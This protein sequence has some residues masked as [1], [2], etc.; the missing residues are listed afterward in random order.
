METASVEIKEKSKTELDRLMDFIESVRISVNQFEQQINVR[1]GY[2]N[3]QLHN[4]ANINSKVLLRI[5]LKYPQLNIL[6]LITGKHKMIIKAN[7]NLLS[8]AS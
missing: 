1:Q 2:L 3:Q 5:S 6:W 8:L 7:E 4:S